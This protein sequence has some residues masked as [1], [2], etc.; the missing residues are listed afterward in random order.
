V[1]ATWNKG[2]RERDRNDI[3][4]PQYLNLFSQFSTNFI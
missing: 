1:A 4:V 2:R 3:W